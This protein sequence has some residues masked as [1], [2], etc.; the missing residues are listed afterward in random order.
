MPPVE[1][2]RTYL[3]LRDRDQLRPARGRPEGARVD[4]VASVAPGLFR[5]LYATVG[6]PWHWRDRL[7]WTDADIARHFADPAVALHVLTHHGV[8]A[9]YYE[10]GRQA[11]GSVEI[12]H[13]GLVPEFVGKGLGGYLL[14]EAVEAA[15]AL[16]ATRVW[17]HTCTLDG[18]AALPNYLARGFSPYR[19]EQYTADLP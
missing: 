3:E 6:G 9:G 12:V 17:L 11:D 18:P 1:V 15:W 5:W 14:G 8:T 4:R 10:L 16:G 13:F 2:T 7:P 19:T